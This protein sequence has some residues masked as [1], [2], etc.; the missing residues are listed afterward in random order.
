M[1]KTQRR[2]HKHFF[3]YYFCFV[4]FRKKNSSEEKR[5]PTIHQIREQSCLEEESSK[6]KRFS[7]YN[8]K[9]YCDKDKVNGQ[10]SS[11]NV[12]LALADNLFENEKGRTIYTDNTSIHLAHAI[13]RRNSRR[14]K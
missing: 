6:W 14:L 13:E 1:N 9:V 8:L 7:T 5:Q 3:S 12:V 10:S 2:I 11:Q 4:F